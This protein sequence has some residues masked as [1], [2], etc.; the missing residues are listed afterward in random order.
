MLQNNHPHQRKG[1]FKLMLG[2]EAYLTVQICARQHVCET[3][4]VA[5]EIIIS[6][7][8][9]QI[10]IYTRIYFEGGK[11]DDAMQKQFTTTVFFYFLEPWTCVIIKWFYI[12]IRKP[13]L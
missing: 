13:L 4:L 8:R 12:N 6:K 1:K 5:A 9:T 7:Q 3:H 10:Q 2:I 11:C